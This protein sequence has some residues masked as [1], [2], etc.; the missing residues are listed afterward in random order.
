MDGRVLVDWLD[1]DWTVPMAARA[2]EEAIAEPIPEASPAPPERGRYSTE[3]VAAIEER[4]R[5][6]GYLD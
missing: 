2:S 5:A 3:D 6:L 1:R 4:L